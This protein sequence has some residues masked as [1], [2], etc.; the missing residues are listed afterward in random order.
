MLPWHQKWYL[1]KA[2]RAPDAAGGPGAS[3]K[4]L[5]GR[6]LRAEGRGDGP[7][8]RS[9]RASLEAWRPGGLV[10]MTL[11]NTLERPW[12]GTPGGS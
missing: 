1:R 12:E 7:G 2:A 3:R 5:V 11:E 10:A 4:G 9:T 8:S 6:P